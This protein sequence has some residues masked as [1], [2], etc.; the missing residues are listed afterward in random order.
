LSTLYPEGTKS[1]NNAR[2]SYRW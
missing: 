1:V 2:I